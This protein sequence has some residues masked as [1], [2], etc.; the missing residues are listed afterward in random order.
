MLSSILL[1]TSTRGQA[2]L[3]AP[4]LSATIYDTA[5]HKAVSMHSRAMGLNAWLD[6]APAQWYNPPAVCPLA[7]R[8]R[9]TMGG[10]VLQDGVYLQGRGAVKLA[11]LRPHSGRGSGPLSWAVSSRQGNGGSKLPTQSQGRRS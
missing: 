1:P 3:S 8:A 2:P 4:T 6:T 9:V 7:L 10:K 11:P 5:V